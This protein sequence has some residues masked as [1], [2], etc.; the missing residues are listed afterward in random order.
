MITPPVSPLHSTR[1][2]SI[3]RK[4]KL[5]PS[6]GREMRGGQ[7]RAHITLHTVSEDVVHLINLPHS[8]GFFSL[9]FIA[10]YLFSLFNIGLLSQ[11]GINTFFIPRAV[12]F[13]VLTDTMETQGRS[14]GLSPYLFAQDQT[15]FM[16]SRGG[17]TR[18]LHE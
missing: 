12:S 7:V 13:T 17:K 1:A 8:L 15:G 18:H 3:D 9:F 2:R 14:S 16:Q 10:F 5:S 11:K 6:A 4:Q